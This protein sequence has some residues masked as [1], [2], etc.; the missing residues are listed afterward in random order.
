[1]AIGRGATS[2]RSGSVCSA[3]RFRS[4]AA[5]GAFVVSMIGLT[6]CTDSRSSPDIAQPDPVVAQSSP[7]SIDG[8]S[9]MR[10]LTVP[11]STLIF[12]TGDTATTT[13]IPN[14]V[15]PPALPPCAPPI[16]RGVP[17]T[18]DQRVNLLDEAQRHASV[19]RKVMLRTGQTALI[20][21]G[22]GCDSAADF[23]T[24]GSVE[25]VGHL[26][27]PLPDSGWNQALVRSTA[28]GAGTVLIT[29]RR[30]CSHQGVTAGMCFG[31]PSWHIKITISMTRP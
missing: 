4:W 22:P 16:V 13:S 5:I 20:D 6:G 29:G 24:V 7:P 27:A 11:P 8:S 12:S 30:T 9:N 23:T 14:S 3:M 19:N 18:G 21:L 26:D 25:I 10:S 28:A 2:A 17:I 1:M 31:D 15:I